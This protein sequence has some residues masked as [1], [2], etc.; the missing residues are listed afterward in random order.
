M[1]QRYEIVLIEQDFKEVNRTA[2]ILWHYGFSVAKAESGIEALEMLYV[3]TPKLIVSNVDLP[4]FSGFD[5]LKS[6]KNNNRLKHIPVIMTAKVLEE[7]NIH[8]SKRLGA[9][10]YIKIPSNCTLLYAIKRSLNLELLE[11]R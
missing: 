11:A 2:D 8:K 3:Q 4:E 5:V 10:A 1:T 7:S 9:A 6:I